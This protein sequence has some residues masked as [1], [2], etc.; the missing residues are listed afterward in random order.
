VTIGNITDL[1]FKKHITFTEGVICNTFYVDEGEYIR[2][3]QSEA[4]STEENVTKFK[5]TMLFEG[6]LTQTPEL[7]PT[8]YVEGLQSTFEDKLIPYSIY[9]GDNLTSITETQYQLPLTVKSNTQYTVTTTV[10]TTK[11][12]YA[13]YSTDGLTEY[14]S[15]DTT[16]ATQTFT[17][18]TSNVL[19]KVRMNPSYSGDDYSFVLNEVKDKFLIVEGDWSYRLDLLTD[20]YFGKYRVDMSSH[21]KN[22]F[23]K[24][25]I[26]E[27][28]YMCPDRNDGLIIRDSYESIYWVKIKPSTTYTISKMTSYR[29]R[30]AFSKELPNLSTEIRIVTGKDDCPSYP[31]SVTSLSDE[32]YLLINGYSLTL[33]P[34]GIT[35]YGET[36]TKEELLNSIQIE[37]G[38]TPTSYEPY[39]GSSKTVYL[40]SPLL[41]GDEL[42]TK[43]GK[44][45]HYHKMGMVVLDG[46]ENWEIAGGDYFRV[47]TTLSN[48][49]KSDFGNNCW[50]NFSNNFISAKGTTYLKN[51]FYIA[52]ISGI[53]PRLYIYFDESKLSTTDVNGFKQWLSEN[54][55]TVVYELASPYYEEISSIED[56]RFNIAT[57]STVEYQSNVPMANTQFLPYRNELPLLESS[58]QYR[59]TFDCDIEGLEL[60]VSLGGT[61]QTITSGLHN[62]LSFITPSLQTDGKLTIDGYGVAKIDNVLIT[63]GDMEYKYFK[64]LKS[65]FEGNKINLYDMSKIET[66]SDSQSFSITNDNHMILKAI[67]GSNWEGFKINDLSNFKENTEYEIVVNVYKNEL[68]GDERFY[69]SSATS[70]EQTDKD[71]FYIDV[72]SSINIIPG[73]LGKFTYRRTSLSDFSNCEC[74]LRT[75]LNIGVSRCVECTIEIYEVGICKANIRIQNPNAPIFGKGGRL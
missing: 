67:N 3:V 34:N 52:N 29:G 35:N 58:T 1:T 5:Q 51:S 33:R 62:E 43:D 25:N 42:L 65:G 11:Y 64:G 10:N 6:D 57:N 56:M 8:E 55:T 72:S 50:N 74:V 28:Q 30:V 13:V 70:E 44:L 41:D 12:Q 14:L 71:I 59:V 21:G 39:H 7:I 31:I 9:N 26:N 2:Y 20:D 49:G 37:E 24:N 18:D 66:D 22:L 75:I 40:N 36:I 47:Y 16:V 48:L 23:D 68:V 27:L 61:S 60:M 53:I 54:P 45:C 69:I 63:K 46:S 17:C 32:N 15:Y 73:Q 19:F 38:S 4:E